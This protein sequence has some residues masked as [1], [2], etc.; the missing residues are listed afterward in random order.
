M[1]DD[2]EMT[3]QSAR[4]SPSPARQRID[5]WLC[6]ARVVK[7]RTLAATVVTEGKVRINGERTDKPAATVKIGDVVTTILRE[8]VSVLKVAGF[9]ERRGSATVAAATYEDLSPPRAVADPAA[10]HRNK[11]AK[12][13]PG[14][15]RPTKRERRE[16]DR[17]KSE[18]E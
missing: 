13:T 2:P 9:A 5:K 11:D 17:F 7:T 12:R 18:S 14:T 10:P 8:H 1:N 16:I 4:A 3:D 15:G 6:H